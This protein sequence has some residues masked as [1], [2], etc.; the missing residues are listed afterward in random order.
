[1]S[2]AQTKL[3]WREWAAVRRA[4]PEAD[5]HAITAQTLGSLVSSRSLTNAQFDLVL[6]SFRAISQPSN[7]AAQM[8]QL[9]QPRTR[10]EAKV[11]LLL[12]Q[13][14]HHGKHPNYA[15][16][17]IEDR[18]GTRAWRTL[19]DQDLHRLIMTLTRVLRTL[20]AAAAKRNALLEAAPIPQGSPCIAQ[21]LSDARA[22]E[23]W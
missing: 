7:L 19:S 11:D 22:N 13:I 21:P 16:S 9:A 12:L 14:E 23:P 1:M 4:Q 17:I 10:A 6:G 8:R 5:R 15:A 20:D 2:P 18:F 3:Y